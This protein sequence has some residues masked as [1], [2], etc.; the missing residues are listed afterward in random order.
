VHSVIE[1]I[2]TNNKWRDTEFSKYK[3]NPSKVEEEL[4]CR[5][6]I[7]M[8]YAHWEGFVID[9]LRTLLKY[10]NSL[11]LNYQQIT[12]KLLVVSLG[13]SYKS[14]SGKQSFHQRIIFTENFHKSLQKVI[15]FKS[16]IETK[17]NLNGKVL[18][19]LCTM[20]DFDIQKFNTISDIDRLVQIR[21]SI[22]HG[23][24]S[25]VLDQPNITQY[26]KA[27]MTATDILLEEIELFLVNKRYLLSNE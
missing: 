5:M 10:L 21:N 26:I 7:P 1:E 12:T 3:I 2:T 6:C 22:A 24:N 16:K 11:N 13:D 9:S 23:E 15:K 27:V 14:L 20:F 17:S 25:F 8:I 4:W 19:E 18:S